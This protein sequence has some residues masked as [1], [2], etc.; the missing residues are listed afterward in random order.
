MPINEDWLKRVAEPAIEA[1]EPLVDPH[2]HLW[3]Q[4]PTRAYGYLD[5]DLLRDLATGHNIVATV[6]VQCRNRYRESGPEHLRPVGE[7][8]WLNGV[9]ERHARTPGA[10]RI[11]AGMVGYA[12]LTLGEAV[13][14][15]LAAHL[16]A[17]PER[18][19]GIRH[20]TSFNPHA[21][22]NAAPRPGLLMEPAFRKGYA[23]LP[24]FKLVYDA[25]LFH[26]QLHELVDLA[27]AQPEVTVVINHFGG[28]L[29][30]PPYSEEREAVLAQWQSAL[31]ELA[32]LPNVFMKL[33]GTGMHLFGFGWD[34]QDKPPTSDELVAKAG[35]FY[36]FAIDTFSPARCMFESNF[37]PDKESLSYGVMWNAFKKIAAAYSPSEKADLY[38]NTAARVYR[39]A[40]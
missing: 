1:D 31:R 24:R 19:R 33:G 35:H 7:T 20:M 30:T 34:R 26:M 22:T 29:G 10:P 6:H 38:R 9:A 5:D 32:A 37:P 21:P 14:E 28:P 16:A 12:D 23:R 15:V 4:G 18:F 40:L 2:H 39:L 36:R 25:W 8:E 27:R 3:E 11:A 13:D 17:A